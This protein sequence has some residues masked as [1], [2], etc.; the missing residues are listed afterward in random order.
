MLSISADT[1]RPAG[2]HHLCNLRTPATPLTLANRVGW[3]NSKRRCL[4]ASVWLLARRNFYRVK[5]CAYRFRTDGF[6]RQ[7]LRRLRA[8]FTAG[9]QKA[10][11]FARGSTNVN[12]AQYP[13]HTEPQA[14]LVENT[15]SPKEENV[16]HGA[17]SLLSF[18]MTFSDKTL[19]NGFWEQR[20]SPKAV[21]SN[22]IASL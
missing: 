8:D 3:G 9:R 17:V 4:P 6:H 7:I 10:Q 16:P 2:R 19:A 12:E 5:K 21:G 20:G 13:C 18:K 22:F 15:F 1:S 14:S 11:D